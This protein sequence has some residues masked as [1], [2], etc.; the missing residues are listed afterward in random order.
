MHDYRAKAYLSSFSSPSFSVHGVTVVCAL[1]S[2][3][4]SVT[5]V[6]GV[7]PVSAVFR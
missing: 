6:L 4:V 2:V 5:A 3:S 1:V 7:L